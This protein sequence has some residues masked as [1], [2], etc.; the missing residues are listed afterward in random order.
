MAIVGVLG[1]EMLAICAVHVVH[2]PVVLVHVVHIVPVHVHVLDLSVRMSVVH[3]ALVA[4][5]L[6]AVND[7]HLRVPVVLACVVHVVHVVVCAEYAV[8]SAAAC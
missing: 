6:Q 4:D 8:L 3:V 2:V 1:H 5:V 7:V